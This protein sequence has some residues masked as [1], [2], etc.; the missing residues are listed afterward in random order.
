MRSL[1]VRMHFRNNVKLITKYDIPGPRAVMGFMNSIQIRIAI[2]PAEKG[3][4][5]T[6][7]T[8]CKEGALITLF[9]HQYT[10]T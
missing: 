3:F 6:G 8:T 10:I 7:S 9:I 4:S 2:S 5:S 1:I